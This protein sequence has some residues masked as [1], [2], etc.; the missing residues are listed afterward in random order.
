M[1]QQRPFCI[2]ASNYTGLIAVWPGDDQENRKFL[3]NREVLDVIHAEDDEAAM[4][5]WRAIHLG[6]SPCESSI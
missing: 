3:G 1:S 2:V 5:K 6:A 4:M